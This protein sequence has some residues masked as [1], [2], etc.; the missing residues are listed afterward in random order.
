MPQQNAT[1]SHTDALV[2]GAGFGGVRTLIELNKLGLSAIALEAGTDVGGTWYWNRYPGART[3]SESWSYCFPFPEIEQAWNWSER[4]PGQAEV[5]RYV[6]FVADHFDVRRQVTFG[7]RVASAS[8]DETANIWAVTTEDGSRYTC[9]FLITCLGHLSIPQ[10]PQF[11]GLDTYAG[12]VYSTAQWPKEEVD[13]TGKRVAV[14]G[15]GASGIQTIPIVAQQAAHLTVFQRTPNYVMPAQNHDLDDAFRQQI[16]DDYAEVWRK[17]R[18]HVFGFPLD[19]AGRTYSDVTTEKERH[20]IFEQGWRDGSFH[21]VFETFDDLILDQRSND[22][23]AEFI[24][25]K[26]RETVED[27]ATAELLT[28]RGYPYISKRP[29]SGTDYYETFNRDN[30]ELVDIRNNPI[31][32]M[33]ATGLRTSQRDYDFDAVIFATGFDAVTGALNSI[34]ITGKGGVKLSEAWAGG[35]EN[36]LGTATPGFPNLVTVCGPQSAYA[37][38]PVIIEAVVTWLGQAL[39]FMKKNNYERLEAT[40]EATASWVAQVDAIF[41]ATLL[42]AGEEVNSWYLGANTP[43]KPRRV[44]F[45]FGG[46]AAYLQVLSDCANKDFEGFD[47]SRLPVGAHR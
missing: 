39:T 24:R 4:Y 13:F 5:Q 22:A 2:I 8:Y 25:T 30:V 26:I 27:P 40:P 32:S 17:A 46:A 9:T 43:G 23:A 7:Q 19:P 36:Y 16:K 10:L 18:S 44:L 12:E 6:A 1:H 20:D 41:N 11:E 28:P 31:E 37:N 33:T 47:F 35:P 3:D 38:I 14:I 29:P 15:T 34:D 21:F 45:Y 42:P